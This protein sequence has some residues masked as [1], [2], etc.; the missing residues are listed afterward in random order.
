MSIKSTAWVHWPLAYIA[1]PLNYANDPK[2]VY[3]RLWRDPREKLRQVLAG[4]TFISILFAA[5]PSQAEVL[6]SFPS[7]VISVFQYAFVLDLQSLLNQPWRFVNLIGAF[8]TFFLFW[9][10]SELLVLINRSVERPDLR[11]RTA[12]WAARLE[13]TMRVRDICGWLFWVLVFLHSML[14]LAPST[15][16]IGAYPREL[17]Q[18]IYGN[19]FLPQELRSSSPREIRL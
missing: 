14:W 18:T 5:F 2:E 15:D 9:Y 19:E 10:G 12:R 4:V 6:K 7:G 17:L 11:D 13:R 3:Y 1:K 8:A 16:W